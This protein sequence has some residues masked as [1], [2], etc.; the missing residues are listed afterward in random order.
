MT[1]R[2]GVDV[3]KNISSETEGNVAV[4]RLKCLQK[5]GDGRSV[6]NTPVLH[7]IHEIPLGK[8]GVQNRRRLPA[9]LRY[10]RFN[11]RPSPLRRLPAELL[12]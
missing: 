9:K 7:V 12:F 10:V 5:K 11:L 8:S 1:N 3:L 4:L 2:K 6:N